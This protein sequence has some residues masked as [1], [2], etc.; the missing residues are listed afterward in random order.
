MV[1]VDTFGA[2]L[3]AL[4]MSLKVCNICNIKCV[5]YLEQTH[6]RSTCI[7]ATL[8][9]LIFNKLYGSFSNNYVFNLK[10]CIML[11]N[12]NNDMKSLLKI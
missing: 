4:A 1:Y 3:L 11:Q 5:T 8:T 12:E 6:I 10:K 9:S 2:Y 7:L